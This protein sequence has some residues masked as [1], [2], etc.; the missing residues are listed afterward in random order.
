MRQLA[1]AAL[2]AGDDAAASG[3]LPMETRTQEA[4]PPRQGH[5]VLLFRDTAKKPDAAE[6]SLQKLPVTD[7]LCQHNCNLRRAPCLCLSGAADLK[8]HFAAGMH[9]N[10]V[11]NAISMAAS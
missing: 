3:E 5:C 2:R 6:P 10:L 11:N 1:A 4:S 9:V 8:H 7:V